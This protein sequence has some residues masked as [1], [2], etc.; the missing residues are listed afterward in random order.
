MTLLNAMVEAL[1]DMRE[2]GAVCKWR[3]ILS[4]HTTNRPKGQE[5]PLQSITSCSQKEVVQEGGK[6][7]HRFTIEAGNAFFPGDGVTWQQTAWAETAHAAQERC[8]L[9]GVAWLLLLDAANF[10]LLDKDWAGGARV[11][12]L[13]AHEMVHAWLLGGGLA[14]PASSSGEGQTNL[15]SSSTGQQ[16]FTVQNPTT[17]QA[18]GRNHNVPPGGE[19]PM[20]DEQR[21]LLPNDEIREAVRGFLDRWI[22]SGGEGAI[23]M[24]KAPGGKK[25]GPQLGNLLPAGALR[26][27]LQGED[28]FEIKDFHDGGWGVQY[29]GVHGLAPLEP[30]E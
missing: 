23:R 7:W 3:R 22:C 29:S 14:Q 28:E 21:N 2:P 5:N 27:W 17:P 10:R 8:C 12:A 15:S 6:V 25:Y 16:G 18:K 26:A 20:P 9:Q 11:V 19:G 30:C 1:V 24:N 13:K 4:K